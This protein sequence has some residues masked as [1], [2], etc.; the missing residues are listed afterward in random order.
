MVAGLKGLMHFKRKDDRLASRGHQSTFIW[1]IVMRMAMVNEITGLILQ[2]IIN[3]LWI[4]SIKELARIRSDSYGVD[5]PSNCQRPRFIFPWS[6]IWFHILI[7][8]N[9]N[10]NITY[11]TD[12]IKC[13][14]QHGVRYEFAIPP[15]WYLY[16]IIC[17]GA[18]T[19][20]IIIR[21][22]HAGKARQT[23]HR[24]L[25]L[26]CIGLPFIAFCLGF[27]RTMRCWQAI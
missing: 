10:R 17:A 8:H 21:L 12:V 25:I 9:R 20:I 19:F 22:K 14:V 26:I 4:I 16:I 7:L 18:D 2:K 27:A 15:I 13:C 1:L 11:R 3:E 23:S 6:S 24:I 5:I